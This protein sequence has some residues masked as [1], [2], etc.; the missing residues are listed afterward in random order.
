[1]QIFFYN[2]YISVPKFEYHHT[3][4]AQNSKRRKLIELSEHLF[5]VITLLLLLLLFK[6]EEKV[7]DVVVLQSPLVFSAVGAFYQ[8]FSQVSDEKVIELMNKYRYKQ[9]L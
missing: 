2:T 3:R 9:G 5:S 6:K 7:D 8:D 1:L 4:I